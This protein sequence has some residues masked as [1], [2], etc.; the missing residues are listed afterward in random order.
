MNYRIVFEVEAVD[1]D[2]DAVLEQLS[3]SPYEIAWGESGGKQAATLFTSVQDP[4]ALAAKV[5]W[6]VEHDIG[7]R[8]VRVDEEFVTISDIARHFGLNRE[9]VRTWTLGMRGPGSFPRPRATVGGGTQGPIRVW[10]WSDVTRWLSANK[11]IE[12]KYCALTEE[13]VAKINLALA[14]AATA[15]SPWPNWN[16]LGPMREVHDDTVN[17]REHEQWDQSLITPPRIVRTVPVPPALAAS[18]NWVRS[19]AAAAVVSDE[20][21]VR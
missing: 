5:A 7:G 12:T 18:V 17:L 19:A 4:V 1:L 11:A 20:E 2:D 13:Q 15:K 9:T 16:P 3:M 21:L 10:A 6:W 14:C 8:L